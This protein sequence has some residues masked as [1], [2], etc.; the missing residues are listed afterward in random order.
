MT[1]SDASS[2]RNVWV[3]AVPAVLIVLIGVGVFFATRPSATPAAASPAS[4]TST[5]AIPV[6]S[7]PVKVD[8]YEDFQ[9]PACGTFE[10]T[11]GSALQKLAAEN[12]ATVN[13]HMMSFLGPESDRAAAAAGCAADAGQFEAFHNY[14]YAHQPVEH[15]D[16]Y[17]TA[18]LVAAGDALGLGQSFTDCVNAGTYAVWT[19]TVDTDA[20]RAGVS[21]TPSFALNGTLLDTKNKSFNDVF[22]EI[23]KAA[24]TSPSPSPS[25]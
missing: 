24:N 1:S 7:G 4:A 6:G 9:C 23:E 2:K 20:A 19:S 25:K 11:Y 16:G 21:G 10:K 17:T 13:Y 15:T 14:L 3:W 5:G 22:A 12:K 18:D 8:V